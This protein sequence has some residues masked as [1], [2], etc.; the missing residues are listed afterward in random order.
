MCLSER[1]DHFTIAAGWGASQFCD[2]PI[3]PRVAIALTSLFCLLPLARLAAQDVTVGEPVWFQPGLAPDVMPQPKSRL[4][5]SYPDEMRKTGEMGYVIIV[6]YVDGTG[7]DLTLS[8]AST[9]VP[10]Q[11][12]VETELQG[13]NFSGAKRGGQPINAQVWMSVIFNP[14]T[15]T[16]KGPDATPRLLAVAPVKSSTNLTPEGQSPIVL[17]KLNLDA[18]GAIVTAEP[19]ERIKAPTLAAIRDSLQKWRFA[20][21]RHGGQTVAAELVMPV[22][23]Q[24]PYL[25]NA[26]KDIPPKVISQQRPKYP[27][28]MARF[29]LRGQVLI[30]FVVDKQGQVREP[31]I[32][33]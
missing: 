7:K 23:C 15:A 20:P 3:N 16:T 33:E 8:T 19:V 27:Y 29:G 28:A 30:D 25:A 1:R 2:M 17:M 18:T 10:F 21:A 13:W 4:R 24:Q 26:G 31:V 22:T 6:R 32:A 12:A 14:R 5:P 9:H 11:R